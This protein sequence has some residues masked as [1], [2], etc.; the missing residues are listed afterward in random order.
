MRCGWGLFV[1]VV[2]WFGIY[3]LVWVVLVGSGEL[4]VCFCGL[5]GWFTFAVIPFVTLSVPVIVVL[6]YGCV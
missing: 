3:G 1:G 5:P 4:Y 2:D 6:V